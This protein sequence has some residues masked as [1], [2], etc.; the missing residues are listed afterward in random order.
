MEEVKAHADARVRLAESVTNKV[1]MEH[2]D[3]RMRLILESE[4][5]KHAKAEVKK[6]KGKLEKTER[7]LE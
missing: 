3:Y 2:E 6:L 4:R 7:L 1:G 5:L